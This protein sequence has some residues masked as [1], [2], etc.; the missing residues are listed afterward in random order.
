MFEKVYLSAQAED[1]LKE[2]LRAQGYEIESSGPVGVLPEGI[3]C[4]PDLAFCRLTPDA[5]FCGDISRLGAK[6]PADIIYNACSTGKYFIHSLKH[7]AQALLNVAKV[8]GLRLVDVPQGYAKCSIAVVS[9]DAIITYDRGIAE[10]ASELEVLLIKPGHINLPGYNTG[11]I[12]G[13]TGLDTYRKELVF[14]GDLSMHPDGDRIRDFVTA[15]GVTVKD[16]PG[17]PLTDIGSIIF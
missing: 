1:D 17:R 14:N 6:Y 10:A 11:F 9:E 16:F 12:G 2:Y 3:S 8:S 7:T 13:C 4:H 15:H 5:L